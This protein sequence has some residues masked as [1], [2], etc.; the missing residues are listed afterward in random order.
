MLQQVDVWHSGRHVLFP[1]ACRD[2]DHLLGVTQ[3]LTEHVTLYKHILLNQRSKGWDSS[4][5]TYTVL[6]LIHTF[7]ITHTDIQIWIY[8]IYHIKITEQWNYTVLLLWLS[9]GL[10]GINH[11]NF[12]NGL[13]TISAAT[14]PWPE[15][16]Q[17][18]NLWLKREGR[19]PPLAGYQCY[20]TPPSWSPWSS[21]Y[22]DLQ[23]SKEI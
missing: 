15:H 17:P 8:N 2:S 14:Y 22:A 16:T 4:S 21:Q 18:W 19:R 7:Y 20:Q 23:A 10:K 13:I 5:N 3:G 1:A 12:T 6:F 9:M 11:V